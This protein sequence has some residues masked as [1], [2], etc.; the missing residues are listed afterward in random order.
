MVRTAINSLLLISGSGPV[1]TPPFSSPGTLTWS[2]VTKVLAMNK[3]VMLGRWSPAV[4]EIILLKIHTEWFK[5]S[6]FKGFVKQPEG[7]LK[8]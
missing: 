6:W 2:S 1:I 8:K 4:A 7:I 3:K 5:K